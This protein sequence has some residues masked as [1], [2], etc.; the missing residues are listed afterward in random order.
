MQ[1]IKFSPDSKIHVKGQRQPSFQKYPFKLV[2]HLIAC[3][4]TQFIVNFKE[5]S[6]HKLYSKLVFGTYRSIR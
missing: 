5:G 3:Q 2:V 4:A 1:N 6:T